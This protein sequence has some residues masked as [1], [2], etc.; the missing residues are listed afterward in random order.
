MC[1]CVY[2]SVYLNII[3]GFGPSWFASNLSSKNIQE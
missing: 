3:Q 2:I 1:V